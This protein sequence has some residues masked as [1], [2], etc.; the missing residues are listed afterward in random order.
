MDARKSQL[1]PQTY[2]DFLEDVVCDLCGSDKYRVIYPSRYKTDDFSRDISQSFI[3]ASSDQARGNIVECLNCQLVY[4]TPRD[5]DVRLL[6]AQT[7][8]DNYY[9]ASETERKEAFKRD[10]KELEDVKNLESGGSRGKLLDVGS[11]YGFFLDV[12][13]QHGW[14]VYG[15]ELSAYQFQYAARNHKN[16]YNLAVDNCAF[17]D[18]S[19][20]VVTLYDVIEH[21]PSPASA[22]V[23]ITRILKDDGL[24][25]INTPNF[26]S[27][28]SKLMGRYWHCLARMHLYYFTPRTICKLLE[29]KGLKVV[30]IKS[31]KTIIK[32]GSAINWA[33]KYP[34]LHTILNFFFGSALVKNIKIRTSFGGNNMVI[35]AQKI[36]TKNL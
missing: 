14:D 27:L 30:K 34:A 22:L 11:S 9:L 36:Q 10:L 15:S 24:L 1:S 18:A 29:K 33:S 12:A 19:F 6:Y 25:V 16:V 3:Y 35:Y 17:P 31:H 5:R 23:G 26:S 2:Q 8:P 20:D 28:A 7:P 32:L 13:K 4:A 21:L